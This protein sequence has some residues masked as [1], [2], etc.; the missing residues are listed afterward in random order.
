MLRVISTRHGKILLGAWLVLGLTGAI[1][2]AYPNGQFERFWFTGVVLVG[3][4][5]VSRLMISGVRV[6]ND[7]IVIQ[8]PL[9]RATFATNEFN[10]FGFE[11]VGVRGYRLTVTRAD[12]RRY[13]TDLFFA[14]PHL[15]PKLVNPF[16]DLTTQDRAV[17]P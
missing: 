5:G 9:T 8:R 14:R 13:P 17:Q 4:A 11:R 3:S 1:R 12:G 10:T 2:V 6:S 15:E 7:V 16:L